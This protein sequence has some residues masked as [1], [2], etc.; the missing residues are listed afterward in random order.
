MRLTKKK[1]L[2]F[3][4]FGVLLVQGKAE[5]AQEKPKFEVKFGTS[6]SLVH[7]NWEEFT[8]KKLVDEEGLLHK[9]DFNLEIKHGRFLISPKVSIYTGTVDYKGHTWGGDKFSTDTS[10]SGLDISLKGG[11]DICLKQLTVTPYVGIGYEKWR[12]N[13]ES[14]YASIGGVTTLVSGYTEKWYSIYGTIGV[15]PRYKLNTS[16][17]IFGNAYLKRPF[18]VKNEVPLFDVTVKP[19]KSWNNYGAEIGIGV[20]NLIKKN[21]EG[22]LSLYYEKDKFKKSNI[23]YSA[24]LDDYVYQPKS[25]RELLGVKLGI[26]F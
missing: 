13:L 14:N 19:G 16:Y 8:N 21:L 3:S 15:A 22:T 25:E 12:R 23:K 20:K 17:Y 7:F 11:Y 9:G 26:K 6:Y 24:V 5:A 4:L 10:Y 2:V 1:L 18:N